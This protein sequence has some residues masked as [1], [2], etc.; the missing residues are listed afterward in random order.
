MPTRTDKFIFYHIPKTGGMWV[1][2]SL[3]RG[4]LAAENWRGKVNTSFSRMGLDR[5]HTTPRDTPEWFKKDRFSFCHVRHPVTWYKSFWC[6][7]MRRSMLARGKSTPRQKEFILDAVDIW[8]NDFQKFM[9][10]V[11]DKYPNGFVS[12][13]YQCYMVDTHHDFIGRQENLVEDT[14]RAYKMAG[15]EFN[16][17]KVRKTGRAN[18]AFYHDYLKKLCRCPKSLEDKIVQVDKW[19]I[20]RF[21]SKTL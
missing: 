8:N 1:S 15:Q 11:I 20:E 10:N 18:V 4:G 6:H 14:I 2:K 17:K 13:L 3:R 7:R 9:T 16:E 21:Y 19:A 12:Y 5:D